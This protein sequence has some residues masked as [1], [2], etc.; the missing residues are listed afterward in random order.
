MSQ[1]R[2]Y[3]EYNKIKTL[4]IVNNK[5][6]GRMS[7][8]NKLL[9]Y[10]GDCPVLLGRLSMFSE[11][12]KEFAQRQVGDGLDIGAGPKG[13][14]SEY[15]KHVT[16]LDGCDADD[17]VVQSLPYITYKQRFVYRLGT[18]QLLP[19]D[20]AC[21]DFIICSCMIQHLNS[22]HELEI[23]MKDMSNV[24]KL[25]GE[26]FLIFKAGTNDSELTHFNQYYQEQRTFR[27]FHPDQVM[28]L[29]NK[30]QL[31]VVTLDTLLDNNWIPYCSIIFTKSVV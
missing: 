29:A 26:L 20:H 17:Q 4:T 19:Y 7:Y 14:N 3:C 27:V 16:N 5:Q 8:K 28:E 9:N 30:Y 18:T 25:G 12:V 23:A 2:N 10:Q 24:L 6:T 31:T 11:Y 22:F 21:K 15:F 13:P 1:L